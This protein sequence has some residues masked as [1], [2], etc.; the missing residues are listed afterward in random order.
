MKF[1]CLKFQATIS[2]IVCL[3]CLVLGGLESSN[4]IKGKGPINTT[5]VFWLFG[6]ALVICLSILFF[7]NRKE[8]AYSK[9]K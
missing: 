6:L 9:A 7:I 5:S 1:P 3:L 2:S 4:I 8:K